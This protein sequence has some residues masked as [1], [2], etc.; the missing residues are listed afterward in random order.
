LIVARLGKLTTTARLPLENGLE[1]VIVH[2]APADPTEAMTFD[3]DDEEI[4]AL[5]GDDPAD[6]VVCGASHVPFDR[7]VSEVR[8]INVGAV[9][10]R[11]TPGVA[12]ATLIETTPLGISVDQFSVEV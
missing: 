7:M 2:G 12:N 4:N 5:I 1:M 3:M 11:P 10:E 6:I 9:G 8:V